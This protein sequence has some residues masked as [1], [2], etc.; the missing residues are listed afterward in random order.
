MV[1]SG[2][3]DKIQSLKS[4][5]VEKKFQIEQYKQKTKKRLF[6]FSLFFSLITLFFLEDS[7]KVFGD[8]ETYL[9]TFG[10]ILFGV[11]IFYNLVVFLLIR[12]RRKEIKRINGRIYRLMKLKKNEKKD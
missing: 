7:Y 10:S 2:K 5:Q 6:L 12:K 1:L 8:I 11:L 9:I 4:R 3:E